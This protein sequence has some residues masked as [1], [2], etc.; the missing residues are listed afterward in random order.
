MAEGQTD[1]WNWTENLEIDSHRYAQLIFDKSAKAIQWRNNSLF[2]AWF[3]NIY[4][5]NELQS[6]PHTLHRNSLKVI[7]EL[8]L[9]HKTIKVLGKVGEN[10]LDLELGKEFFLRCDT[11]SI[12]HKKKNS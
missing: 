1:N 3:W 8:N 5:Q 11:K 9:K 4:M 10:L 2:N 6:I 7:I 12:T